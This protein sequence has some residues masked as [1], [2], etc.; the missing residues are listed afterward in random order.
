MTASR[1]PVI[2]VA[3]VAERDGRF[4]VTRRLESTHLPGLWEFPG[5]KCEPDES[6]E[7]CLI[8]ELDEEL[9]VSAAIG[10][11]IVV[12]E[13]EYPDRTVRLHFRLCTLAG[14]PQPRLGQELRWVT[15]SELRALALP[16]GDRELVERL[17]RTK[18]VVPRSV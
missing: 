1:T 10:D 2:V 15:R 16:E 17:T 7:A 11:E 18:G 13:H 14:E 9:G 8:R 12:T 3:G 5:G 6:Q 4:L